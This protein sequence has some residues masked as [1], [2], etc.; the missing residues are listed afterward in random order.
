MA[1]STPQRTSLAVSPF[2]S[3]WPRRYLLPIYSR[4]S[5]IHS[6][7]PPQ[8]FH[9]RSFH[10]LLTHYPP[11]RRRSEKANRLSDVRSRGS[12]RGIPFRFQ[13]ERRRGSTI[14]LVLSIIKR[15]RDGQRT[16][17]RG[18][19]RTRSC[20]MDTAFGRGRLDASPGRGGREGRGLEPV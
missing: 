14:L 5:L 17:F 13:M 4:F 16:Q 1:F 20:C 3:G 2:A 12:P 7:S 18:R 8:F 19:E 11:G 9:E 6:I 10:I 15:F